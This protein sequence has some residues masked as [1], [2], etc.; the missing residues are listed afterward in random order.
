MAKLGR[1][2]FVLWLAVCLLAIASTHL[3]S[4]DTASIRGGDSVTVRTL[5]PRETTTTTTVASCSVIRLDCTV[6]LGSGR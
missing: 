1:R 2:L 5:A 4:T 6:R 3:P